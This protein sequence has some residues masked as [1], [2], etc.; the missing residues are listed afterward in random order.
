M[1][2]NVFGVEKQLKTFRAKG[3]VHA[4]RKSWKVAFGGRTWPQAEDFGEATLLVEK[5][6]GHTSMRM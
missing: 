6:S 2:T 4:V 5:T 1:P 3:A